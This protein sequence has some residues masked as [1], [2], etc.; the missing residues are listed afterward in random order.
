MSK[1]I[2]K[3]VRAKLAATAAVTTIV[4]TRMYFVNATPGATMPYLTIQRVSSNPINTSDGPTDNNTENVTDQITMFAAGS[5]GYETVK[6]LADAVRTALWG[7]TDTGADP[8][9][10]ASLLTDERD[11]FEQPATGRGTPVYSVQQD[12]SLWFSG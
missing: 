12:Y 7:W 10:S 3:S 2:E 4:S 6:N 8:S 11:D 5:K 1:K 9:V